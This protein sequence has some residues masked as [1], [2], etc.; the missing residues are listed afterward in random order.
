MRMVI[1]GIGT[2]VVGSFEGFVRRGGGINWCG[3]WQA[4][5]EFVVQYV[6]LPFLFIRGKGDGLELDSAI[7]ACL[8]GS[9]FASVVCWCVVVSAVLLL[10][11]LSSAIALKLVALPCHWNFHHYHFNCSCRN[12]TPD[13]PNMPELARMPS[14]FACS[15]LQLSWFWERESEIIL[16]LRKLQCHHKQ[17]HN[18]KTNSFVPLI[19]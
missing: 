19:L 5:C 9:L 14:S 2:L 16:G 13:C 18:S 12:Q 11:C 6:L 3:G 15:M 1:L 10:L 8:E 4:G 7:V 17:N